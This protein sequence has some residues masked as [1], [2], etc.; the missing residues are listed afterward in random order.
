MTHVTTC[1]WRT[2]AFFALAGLLLSCEREVPAIAVI[3]DGSVY[4]AV[5]GD[6]QAYRTAIEKHEGKPT[7]LLVTPRENIDMIDT[8]AQE[9]AEGCLEY[10]Y[11]EDLLI[12]AILIGNLS[13]PMS[14]TELY[15]CLV[16]NPISS[17]GESSDDFDAVTRSNLVSSTDTHSQD[18]VPDAYAYSNRLSNLL[19][20]AIAALE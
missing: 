7:V 14:A 4:E 5:A 12:R 19:L 20:S 15:P 18:N 8:P 11:G 6:V 16:L 13:A 3:V 17:S 1:I 2:C 10:L 9:F